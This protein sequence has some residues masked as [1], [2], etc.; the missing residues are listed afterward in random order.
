VPHQASANIHPVVDAYA[1]QEIISPPEPNELGD[2]RVAVHKT[3]TKRHKH[4]V[5]ENFEPE[6]IAMRWTRVSSI[7]IPAIKTKRIG[8][9]NSVAEHAFQTAKMLSTF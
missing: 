8:V 6:E 3:A 2:I 4:R 9:D 7:R 1:H 5:A